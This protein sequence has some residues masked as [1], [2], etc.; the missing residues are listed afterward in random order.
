MDKQ[1]QIDIQNLKKHQEFWALKKALEEFCDEMESI[2]DLDLTEVSRVT[3]GEEIAGRVWA[4]AKVRDL[5]S[6][7]GLIDKTKPRI[8]DRTGE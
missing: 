5:L 8:I 1:Q 3:L 2:K 4:S 6:S 7:L